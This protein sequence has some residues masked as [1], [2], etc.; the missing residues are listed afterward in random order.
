ME[1]VAALRASPA[2]NPFVDILGVRLERGGSLVARMAFLQT[3]KNE[4]K[5][6]FESVAVADSPTPANH[7][8]TAPD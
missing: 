1:S 2:Y 5:S 4:V 7:A 6:E 8:P 3:K